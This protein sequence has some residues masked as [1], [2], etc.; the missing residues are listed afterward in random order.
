MTLYRLLN[1]YGCTMLY[2]YSIRW[3]MVLKEVQILTVINAYY[4]YY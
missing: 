3:L 2:I 1:A 4:G